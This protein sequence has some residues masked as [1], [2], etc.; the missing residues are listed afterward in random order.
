M[1]SNS[2]TAF[3]AVFSLPCH[4]VRRLEHE[5]TGRAT[6]EPDGQRF[7]LRAAGLLIGRDDRDRR[8]GQRAPDG[9]NCPQRKDHLHQPSLHVEHAGAANLI[10]DHAHRHGLLGP[11]R[12]HGVAVA[13]QELQRPAAKP[14][15]RPRQ[16]HAGG[17]S[18]PHTAHG[19]AARRELRSQP[20]ERAPDGRG[21]VGGR[22]ERGQLGQQPDHRGPLVTQVREDRIGHREK[23]LGNGNRVVSRSAA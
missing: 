11:D 7:R 10:V 2:P 5:R 15:S 23:P 1:I 19:H 6:R 20:I 8:G 4:A 22:F 13:D 18:S 21:I 9:G 3:R 16:Q 17:S 12:P 14:C